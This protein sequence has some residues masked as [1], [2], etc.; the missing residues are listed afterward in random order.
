MRLFVFPEAIAGLLLILSGIVLNI[1][2]DST[3]KR[4]RTTVK[5]FENTSALFED[6]VF[7]MTR[8]P[9][10]PG[11]VLVVAWVSLLFGSAMPRCIFA[12]F[13]VIL[14]VVFIRAEERKLVAEFGGRFENYRK[15]VRRWL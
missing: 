7:G 12:V 2:A 4:N 8:N 1:S 13:A 14:H 5:P 10:Y 6:G 9:M 15:R 3:M 11:M